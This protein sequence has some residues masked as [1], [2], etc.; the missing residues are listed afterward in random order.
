MQT[1]AILK[2][3]IL[4]KRKGHSECPFIKSG[5]SKRKNI[6]FKL[7]SVGISQMRNYHYLC[8][9]NKDEDDSLHVNNVKLYKTNAI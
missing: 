8:L 3:S 2:H 5:A 7:N 1:L 6:G 4:H 9:D